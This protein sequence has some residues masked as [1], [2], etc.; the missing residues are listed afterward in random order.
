MASKQSKD[1]W[2]QQ[3]YAKNHPVHAN[4]T[5]TVPGRTE[6]KLDQAQLTEIEEEETGTLQIPISYLPTRTSD[7]ARPRTLAAGYDLKT[8][9]MR[10]DF[11]DG[12]TYHY[13]E[14][15]PQIWRDFQNSASPGKFMNR[16][17]TQFAYGRVS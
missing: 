11:R 13:Y 9:T 4:T 1:W 7:E 17:M 6:T 8:H 12:A 14:V 10:I 2:T 3:G 15:P 16:R 5:H